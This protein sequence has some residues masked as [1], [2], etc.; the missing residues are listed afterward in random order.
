MTSEDTSRLMQFSP[1]L[2]CMNVLFIQVNGSLNGVRQVFRQQLGGVQCFMDYV[3]CRIDPL[4]SLQRDYAQVVSIGE[5][6][7]QAKT[8]I[9]RPSFLWKGFLAGQHIQLETEIN[10]VRYRRFYSISSAPTLFA[11]RGLISITVKKIPGGRISNHLHKTLR[12]GDILAIGKAVG[13]FICDQL[14]SEQLYT[15]SCREES[16]PIAE[17][18]KEVLF[19]AAGSGVT[20]FKSM[21][22]TLYSEKPERKVTLILY[23]NRADELIFNIWLSQLSEQWSNFR[24]ITHCGE[25]ISLDSLR[26]DCPDMAQRAVYL[27]GPVGFMDKTIRFA[28][29][30]DVPSDTIR[31]ENFGNVSRPSA[32]V[33]AAGINLMLVEAEVL[34]TKTGKKIKSPGGKTLLE[35]AEQSGLHPKYG[36]RRGICHECTCQREGG[37]IFNTLTGALVPKEQNRIQACISV[38]VGDLVVSDW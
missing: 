5:E 2:R 13:R 33:D 28:R 30:L 36:C 19:I 1:I 3:L 26:S 6:T 29:E 27:C 31:Q 11:E 8:F 37:D 14:D 17:N 32:L 18:S 23:A 22:E 15:K 9:L 21:L 35:L 10:G 34:F 25:Q 12:V 38:P 24:L 16:V 20:P 4:L 7:R